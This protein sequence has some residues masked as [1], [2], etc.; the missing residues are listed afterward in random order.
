MGHDHTEMLQRDTAGDRPLHEGRSLN[1]K[2]IVTIRPCLARFGG[3]LY[4]VSG[5]LRVQVPD[6]TKFD[7]IENYVEFRTPLQYAEPRP[8]LSAPEYPQPHEDDPIIRHVK[9][10]TGE[11]YDVV[12]YKGK[13]TC[14]CN[15]FKYRGDCKH[16]SIRH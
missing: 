2:P 3:H 14:T 7:E 11:I 15:G 10:S 9:G 13:V 6:S 4:V 1:G 16:L 5:S 12:T 8:I